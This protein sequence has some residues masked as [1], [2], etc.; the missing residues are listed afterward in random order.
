MAHERL[1]DIPGQGSGVQVKANA[2]YVTE[3]VVDTNAPSPRVVISFGTAT[4]QVEFATGA[5][6]QAFFDLWSGRVEDAR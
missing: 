3:I 6:A 2:L 1:F 4:I 5:E